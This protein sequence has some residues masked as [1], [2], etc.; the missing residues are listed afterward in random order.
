M[1]S[2]GWKML[3]VV[4]LLATAAVVASRQLKDAPTAEPQT[5]WLYDIETGELFGGPTL[6]PE[7]ILAPSGSEAVAA[8]VY[9]CG[10]CSD[11]TQR[12][13]LHLQKLQHNAE[14]PEPEY[15]AEPTQPPKWVSIG[16]SQGLAVTSEKFT[17]LR[18]QCGS[19]PLKRCRPDTP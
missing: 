12:T 1:S 17:A 19:Q 10:D 2:N 6:T 3:A 18:K 16:S 9:S 5:Q 7:P 15:V 4:V 11:P 14:Q 13:I 8:V